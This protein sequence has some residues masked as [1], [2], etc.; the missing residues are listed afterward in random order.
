MRIKEIELNK[1]QFFTFLAIFTAILF[2]AGLATNT[3]ALVV[4]YKPLVVL[5]LA[6]AIP[7]EDAF[8][9]LMF[10]GFLFAAIG[11]LVLEISEDTFVYGLLFF[12]V[13]HLFYSVAFTLRSKR[14]QLWSLAIFAVAGYFVFDWL[15]DGIPRDMLLPVAVYMGVI[16]IMVWRAFVQRNYDKYAKW[17]FAGAVVFLL[18]DTLIAVNKFYS[19]IEGEL[20][21]IMTTY[22][23]AQAMI[24]YAVVKGKPL[25]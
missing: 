2:Y 11:D 15:K 6:L 17:A 8:K 7:R 19:P 3:W 20:W 13:T 24:F 12:L 10:A 5:F 22:W 1:T 14:L 16:I 9:K 23:L 4:S 25:S 18:S 21:Y